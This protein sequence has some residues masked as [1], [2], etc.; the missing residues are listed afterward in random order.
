MTFLTRAITAD[1][2]GNRQSHLA[3]LY[4]QKGQLLQSMDQPE[5]AL[6]YFSAAIQI[7]KAL[8]L[9]LIQGQ[10]YACMSETYDQ[11]GNSDKSRYYIQQ[12]QHLDEAANQQPE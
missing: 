8:H 9:T 3:R 5:Q 10:G 6:V 7:A 2:T 4:I 11:L 1:S 12:K